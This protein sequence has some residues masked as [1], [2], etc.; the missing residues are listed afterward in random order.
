MIVRLSKIDL[1]LT[2]A[3]RRAILFVYAMQSQ[4]RL[5]NLL[6]LGTKRKELSNSNMTCTD[7]QRFGWLYK[8]SK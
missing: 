6:A 2:K 7:R 4:C 3:Q 1:E 8:V 5:L